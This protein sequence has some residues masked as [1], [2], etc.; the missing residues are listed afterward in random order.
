[1]ATLKLLLLVPVDKY[2]RLPV[3]K[4]TVLVKLRKALFGV[5][6]R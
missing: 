6:A 4:F 1:M 3:W 5:Y 2:E